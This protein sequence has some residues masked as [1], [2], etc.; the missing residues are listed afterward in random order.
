MAQNATRQGREFFRQSHH[1]LMGETSE[2]CMLE[3]IELIF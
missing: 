2:H 3:L 1:R